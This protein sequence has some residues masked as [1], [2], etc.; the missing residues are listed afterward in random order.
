[1]TNYSLGKQRFT[2]GPGRLF[3]PCVI[4]SSLT[5]KDRGLYQLHQLLCSKGQRGVARIR[6]G[7]PLAAFGLP[8]AVGGQGQRGAGSCLSQGE[9]PRNVEL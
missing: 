4:A 9:T 7:T 8:A 1:M 6:T 5:I 2:W 3:L